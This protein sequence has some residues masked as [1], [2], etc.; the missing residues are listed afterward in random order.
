MAP[1][2]WTQTVLETLFGTEKSADRRLLEP[3]LGRLGASWGR[4]GEPGRLREGVFGVFL[5]RHAREFILFF[6][7]VYFYIIFCP[8][9]PSLLRARRRREQ[10][11]YFFVGRKPYAPFSRSARRD[12]IPEE[13]RSKHRIKHCVK[14]NPT[15]EQKQHFEHGRF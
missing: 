1:G 13:T 2:F 8:L 4:F 7:C 6:L 15:R 3:S 9:L 5:G 12:L 14:N 10:Q 11:L